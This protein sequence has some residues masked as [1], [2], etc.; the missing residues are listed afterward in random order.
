VA[1]QACIVTSKR[2]GH[3]ANVQGDL[4]IMRTMNMYCYMLG[5]PSS[6]TL[7]DAIKQTR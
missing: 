5:P 3:T 7:G 4:K 6:A 2:S 1:V